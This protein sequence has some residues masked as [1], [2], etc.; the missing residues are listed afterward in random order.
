MENIENF[1]K[2]QKNFE[3][4]R[5]LVQGEYGWARLVKRKSDGKRFVIKQV[6]AAFF[7]EEANLIAKREIDNMMR[8]QGISAHILE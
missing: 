7:D 6:Y 8:L 2:F 5:D 4:G 1:Y 3:Y